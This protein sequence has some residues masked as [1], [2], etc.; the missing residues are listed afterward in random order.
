MTRQSWQRALKLRGSFRRC[1]SHGC[2]SQATDIKIKQLD[3]IYR[4][5]NFYKDQLPIKWG[6]IASLCYG[7][8]QYASVGTE[9]SQQKTSALSLPMAAVG[10][11]KYNPKSFL[12]IDRANRRHPAVFGYLSLNWYSVLCS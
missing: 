10:A 6:G 5:S 8:V 1:W 4:I 12:Y 11:K 2:S 3:R 7:R 9:L